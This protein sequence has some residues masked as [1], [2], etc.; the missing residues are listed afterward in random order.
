MVC[1]FFII[2]FG[3]KSFQL[4]QNRKKKKRG[5]TTTHRLLP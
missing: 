5:R 3:R 1:V 2:M 4:A